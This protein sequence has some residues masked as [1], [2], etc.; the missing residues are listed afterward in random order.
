[1]QK[2][3]NP[4][5]LRVWEV[6]WYNNGDNQKTQ[7]V[8]AKTAG[9]ALDLAIKTWGFDSTAPANHYAINITGEAI[10]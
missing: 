10:A 7:L 6:E 3:D 5:R 8:I 9:E 2:I 1:M 4:V